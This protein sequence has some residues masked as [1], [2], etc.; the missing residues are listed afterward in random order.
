MD[1]TSGAD[2]V[3]LEGELDLA[4]R[5]MLEERFQRLA[6]VGVLTVDLSKVTYLDS[7]VLTILVN[8]WKARKN[9]EGSMR[10]IPSNSL[11]VQRV[12]SVTTLDR[13]LPFVKASEQI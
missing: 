5:P 13:T 11:A 10:I 3:T 7:S 1:E 4:N 6:H 8:V 2:T 9:T 12:F